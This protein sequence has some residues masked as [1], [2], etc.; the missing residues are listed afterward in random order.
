MFI[1]CRKKF[2]QDLNVEMRFELITQGVK[3]MK[4]EQYE[5][6]IVLVFIY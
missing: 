4:T 5:Q 2:V 6:K 3:A 1:L